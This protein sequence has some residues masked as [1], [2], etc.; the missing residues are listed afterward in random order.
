MRKICGM[1]SFLSMLFMVGAAGS[2]Y[3]GEI[4]PFECF[5]K[6]LVAGIAM[7]FFASISGVFCEN[8]GRQ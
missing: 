3:A 7:F 6:A 4:G 5:V 1:M 2:M 8:S